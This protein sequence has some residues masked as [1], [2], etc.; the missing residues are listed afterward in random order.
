VIGYLVTGFGTAAFGLAT[1]AWHVLLA[2]ACAWLGRGVRTPVRKAL[3]A[4][5]VTRE[6]YGRAFGF[7]RMMDTLGAIVGPAT[8]LVLLQALNFNY[9]ALFAWTLVPSTVAAALIAFA[10]VEKTR[11][12]VPHLSFGAGRCALR[13]AGGRGAP[14]HGL[15]RA[16]DGERRGRFSF[17]HHRRG[18]LDS[19]RN[20]RSVR[21]QR[22]ALCDG[23]T[24]GPAVGERVFRPLTFLLIGSGRIVSVIHEKHE[25]AR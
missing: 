17:E 11:P 6:T 16:G 15:R 19:F 13:R 3:L 20:K 23:R 7:E 4:A 12:R 18:A 2:R 9:P 22:G 1:T 24:A 10:V 5:S 8:A 14:R 21:L 25:S